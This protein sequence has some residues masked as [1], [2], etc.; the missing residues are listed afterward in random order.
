MATRLKQRIYRH[1][2][3]Q[4]TG[5]EDMGS[6]DE[7]L[8][9]LTSDMV[10]ID[11]SVVETEE[12]PRGTTRELANFIVDFL[13]LQGYTPDLI[14]F[15][16]GKSN[17]VLKVGSG[18]P[19]LVL[20]GHMD[21]VPP[22][23]RSRWHDDPFSGRIADGKVYGRGATDMK[24]G[25]A[26]ILKLASDLGKVVED[27]GAGT[28]IF[29]A[30][31]DEEVG[32]WNGLG[33]LVEQGIVTGDAAIIAEPSGI[34][35]V[36][37]GEKGL[38]QVKLKVKGV[39]AHG[40]TP[41]LGD[42]AIVKAF[43]AIDYMNE[44]VKAINSKII[45]PGSLARVVED[46]VDA[47]LEELRAATP[48]KKVSVKEVE[49]VV[50]KITFSPNIIKGGEKINVVPDSCE[51]YIDMRIPVGFE[52]KRGRGACETLVDTMKESLSQLPPGDGLR[53]S[54][55]IEI[56]N[57]SEPNYTD[58]NS[59]IVQY[60]SEGV[61][62]VIGVRPRLKIETG[63]TDGRYLRRKG[64]PTAVYGPG[65]PSLA[66]AYD[67]YVRVDDLLVAYRAIRYAAERFFG[68]S[69]GP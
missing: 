69:P 41:L 20:A 34:K 19:T 57:Q 36:A 51:V 26:V 13:Q 33:S 52:G 37:I 38:C 4:L 61:R 62:R 65:E 7:E 21:V 9:K 56:I 40:S 32:G 8:A 55:D 6:L 39:P 68:L 35:N 15:V 42:N 17:V 24:G 44:V 28:L 47:F 58:P 48:L 25:L 53:D 59:A 43:K 3:V 30:T 16:E 5:C 60:I 18:R 1:V 50:T 31:A 12:G 23:D 10:K 66:H 29:A 22:G 45:V 54:V 49:E 46:A 11:T 63:A 2:H 27:R 67:E 14:E 64:V